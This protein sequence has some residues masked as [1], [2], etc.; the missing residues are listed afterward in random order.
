VIT[1][2]HVHVP[3]LW[4]QLILMTAATFPTYALNVTPV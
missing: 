2:A 4:D 3:A 1:A